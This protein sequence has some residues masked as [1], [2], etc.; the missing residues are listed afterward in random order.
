MEL[1]SFLFTPPPLS[2][3]NKMKPIFLSQGGRGPWSAH[4]THRRNIVQ[5]GNISGV[6]GIIMMTAHE[7]K[8]KQKQKTQ[9]QRKP[10]I[11]LSSGLQHKVIHFVF[12]LC[13]VCWGGIR[14]HSSVRPASI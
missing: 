2:K 3:E 6:S 10:K 9:Q 8:N 11:Q 4:G 5:L 1:Y 13:L 14:F 7:L 12:T